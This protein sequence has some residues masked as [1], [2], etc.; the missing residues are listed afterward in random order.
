[1]K[2]ETKTKAQPTLNGV[3]LEAVG[4]LVAAIQDQPAEAKA[5]FRAVTHWRGGVR[6][7]TEVREW[8]LG[9]KA[10]PKSWDIEVDEPLELGGTHTAPNPQEVLLAAFNACVMATYVAICTVKGIA[11][12]SLKIES[13]GELDLRGFLA[14]DDATDAGY[15]DLHYRVTFDADANVDALR[16]IHEAVKRQ[17]PNFFNMARAIRLHDTLVIE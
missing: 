17:S 15:H 2:T 6:S 10:L 14:L 1:M 4:R 13:E 3:N 7:R 16:E 5:G 11:V 12:R 8:T 9:G